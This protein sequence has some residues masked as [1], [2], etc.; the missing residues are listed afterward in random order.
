M[1]CG[2]IFKPPIPIM[3]KK[4]FI[5]PFFFLKPFFAYILAFIVHGH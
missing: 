2:S 5:K 4:T 1:D 3:T